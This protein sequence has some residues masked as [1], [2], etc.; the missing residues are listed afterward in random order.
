MIAMS[1]ID[2]AGGSVSS[3]TEKFPWPLC[4]TKKAGLRRW[5]AKC[6]DRLDH[7]FVSL[8]KAQPLTMNSKQA[9]NRCPVLAFSTHS[10]TE[11]TRIQFAV[12]SF[13]DAVH[14]AISLCGK[15]LA[16]AF[17]KIRS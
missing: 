1:I 12:A 15:F 8:V 11:N 6:A 10:F 4:L 13:A 9:F 5:P 17:L 2:K 14:D 7:M 3:E 16:Q